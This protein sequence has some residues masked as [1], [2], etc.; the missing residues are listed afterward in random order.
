MNRYSVFVMAFVAVLLINI[1]IAD[2]VC[3]DQGYCSGDG[4]PHGDVSCGSE[5]IL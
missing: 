5:L 2:I 1:A 3:N 4:A